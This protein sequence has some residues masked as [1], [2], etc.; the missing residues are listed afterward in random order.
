MSRILLGFILLICQARGFDRALPGYEFVFPRDHFNHPGFQVEWWYYTGNVK[1]AAGRSFG[2]ELT[3][4]RT[5]V[6]PEAAS[7]TTSPWDID[8]LYLA[9][10]ALSDIAGQRFFKAERLNRAGPG[11]A[12]IDGD[13]G[14][15]WNGNWEV[16]WLNPSDPLGRQALRAVAEDFSLELELEPSKPAIVHGKQGVSQRAAGS[17]K[18][19]HYISFT[20]LTAAGAIELEG[21]RYEV[22]G[23][24]WMDHEFSTDALGPEQVGWD[25]MSVQLDNGAE[26]MFYRLRRADGSADPHSSGT[27]VD[28]QGKAQHLSWDEVVMQPGETWQSPE[29]GG[30]YPV[31]WKVAV[32]GLGLELEC[33]TTFPAQEVFSPRGISPTYWEGAVRYEGRMG[34]RAVT[35]V[36]YLE[37][38]G[39]D[40]P[41]RLG[42]GE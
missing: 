21:T 1:S 7:K 38:T 40:Q 39:Y 29:T 18:A 31:G 15:V 14:R 37:M 36:G 28:R 33:R 12:G 16:V 25:W 2:F 17:G 24:A 19:S 42:L 13:E 8:Q 32:P 4:F 11:L 20:R 34:G 41:I 6:A 35:G 5:A 23:S 3:F 10:L 30:K 9:H 22:S 26:V 27:F